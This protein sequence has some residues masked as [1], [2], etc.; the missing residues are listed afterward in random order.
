[1]RNLICSAAML[2]LIAGCGSDGGKD[3][4]GK[5]VNVKSEKRTVEIVK[6]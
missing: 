4:L 5:W 1:M 6:N 2:A 3:F